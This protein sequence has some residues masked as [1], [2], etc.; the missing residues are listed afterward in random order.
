[1]VSSRRISRAYSKAKY[2]GKGAQIASAQAGA[3]QFI[4]GANFGEAA[5]ANMSK[6]KAYLI[7]L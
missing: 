5:F 1:M 6:G 3:P 4:M 2:Q 7:F